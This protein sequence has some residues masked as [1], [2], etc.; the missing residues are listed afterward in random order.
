MATPGGRRGIARFAMTLVVGALCTGV[1][2]KAAPISDTPPDPNGVPSVYR[3]DAFDAY[4]K[5]KIGWLP[6]PSVLTAAEKAPEATAVAI[7]NQHMA[8]VAAKLATKKITLAPLDTTVTA[9]RLKVTMA[10]L[11]PDNRRVICVYILP[12]NKFYSD[13]IMSV[14]RDTPLVDPRE[15]WDEDGMRQGKGAVAQF[16]TD[17]LRVNTWEQD[18]FEGIRLRMCE[19]N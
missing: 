14:D 19:G 16:A 9:D 8:E 6:A 1:S 2:A 4:N 15:V 3:S 5:V 13:V 7:I 10:G 12:G 18:T 17:T 11:L